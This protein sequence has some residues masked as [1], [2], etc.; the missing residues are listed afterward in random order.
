MNTQP[1]LLRAEKQR[2]HVPL[3]ALAA[4]TIR[5]R[6]TFLDGNDPAVEVDPFWKGVTYPTDIFEARDPNTI[7][8]YNPRQGTVTNVR[9]LF[10]FQAPGDGVSVSPQVDGILGVFDVVTAQKFG[11]PVAKLVPG[12]RA[13]ARPRSRPTRRA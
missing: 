11:L 7:G 13:R 5:P 8:N 1:P 4:G 2:R 3:D 9:R 12:E 6:A 10:N